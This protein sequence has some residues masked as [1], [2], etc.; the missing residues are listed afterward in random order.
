MAKERDDERS[1]G[2]GDDQGTRVGRPEAGRAGETPNDYPGAGKQG[3]AR[4][5]AE[6]SDSGTPRS[7]MGS[8]AA[9]GIHGARDAKEDGRD[10]S[11][12]SSLS[13]TETGRESVEGT[14]RSGS[15]PLVERERE[16]TSSY[17]G[18]GGEPRTP[19]D[20]PH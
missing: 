19:K 9:E 18:A 5:A 20:G 11:A 15:E 14:E 6:G 13:E 17:G 2:Y 8:E 10:A 7:A 3:E 16:N 4:R 12:P 1:S